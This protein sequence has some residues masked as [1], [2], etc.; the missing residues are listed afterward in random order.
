MDIRRTILLMIF[1]FSLLMLWN[2]WQMHQTGTSLFGETPQG[3]QSDAPA[4][5][6]GGNA[7][8]TGAVPNAAPTSSSAAAAQTPLAPAAMPAPS[9]TVVVSTDVLKLTFDLNG[10][11]L[12]RAELL[13]YP[14]K[15]NVSQPTVLLEQD[16]GRTYIVQT[17]VVG[18]EGTN[19]PTHLAPF[20]LVSSDLTLQGDAL[21]VT[22][23][24]ESGGVRVTKT[25]N[26]SRGQYIVDVT[27]AVE[28][29]TS[30]SVTPSVYLQITR[31]GD[32]PEDTSSFY[33]TFTGP[34]VYSEQE[35]FQKVSF[36]D[37]AKKDGSFIKTSDNGWFAM[38]QH[39][40][41]TA[42]VP[43]QGNQRTYDMAQVGEN[44]YAV[45]SI[46]GIG[47]IGPGATSSLNSKLWVGPQDQDALEALAPGLDLVVDYGWLTIIAKPLFILMT[48]IHDV[49]GNWG[50]TIVALT[51]LIKAVF[52]PLS[53]ASYRS[54][55][56]MKLVA[57]RLKALKEKFGDD[58]QKLNTAM[59][60]MYRNEK[61]NPLGGCLPIVIQ[62]PVFISLYWVLLA[63][64]EM[65][66]APWVLWVDDLSARDPLYILP[67]IMMATMFLQIKLNPTPPDPMQARVMMIM[68]IV[69]GGFMFFFPAGLVLYWVVNNILSIAQQWY[70]TQ[71]MS[72]AANQPHR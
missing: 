10:A 69:F 37:I 17:G 68:P 39:Y 51:V 25:F 6:A 11:Q 28:N 19:Y 34:A 62:I 53:A 9:E 13:K 52:Y 3:A 48:W 23:V 20:K 63:S 56:K 65:R 30:E 54:M 49:L 41:V 50:W 38:I 29:L 64:V 60:E 15:G 43:P 42:W 47:D 70:I 44:L 61:I 31:D 2:N 71:K 21:P 24:S 57:P 22:F 33:H 36:S 16:G 26:F 32:D 40:F 1:A 5:G 12:I 55:A 18:P 58:R 72:Q 27:H 7:Q 67:V 59:M 4:P 35:K 14:S 46:E 8:S 66:G 45:R